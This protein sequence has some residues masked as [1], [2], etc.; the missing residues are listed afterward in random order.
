MTYA[1]PETSIQDANPVELFTFTRDNSTWN[2][3][4]ASADYTDT[5]VSPHVTYTSASIDAGNVEAS[6]EDLRNSLKLTVSREFAIAELFRVAAP[7]DVVAV[8]IR[9][10]HRDDGTPVVAWMGRVLSCTTSGAEAVIQCEPLTIS[11]KRTGLRQLYQRSCPHVLYGAGCG[12]DKA[13]WDTS[14]T[15]ATISGLTITVGAL[16]AGM[17]YGG[18]FIEWIDGNGNTERRFIE[19]VSTSG[20]PET[21]TLMLTQAFVGLATSDTITVYPGCAHNTTSCNDEFSN[22]INYGGWPYIPVKNIFV[23]N[24]VF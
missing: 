8:T 23:G 10:L 1:A 4:S 2:Y 7:T 17:S 18:G 3:T 6:N 21:N 14:A 5:T 24:P 19:S 15:V 22:I 11:L 9:R 13:D 16:M 12:L 20:S